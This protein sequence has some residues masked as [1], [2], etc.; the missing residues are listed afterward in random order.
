LIPGCKGST[1]AIKSALE[2]DGFGLFAEQR[3]VSR[4]CIGFIGIAPSDETYP[5]HLLALGQQE[6]LRGY[7]AWSG[8]GRSVVNGF[9]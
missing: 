7:T 2:T 8:V 6:L 5:L 1:A 9:A 3:R 4:H